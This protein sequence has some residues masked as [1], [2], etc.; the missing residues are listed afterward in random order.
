VLIGSARDSVP[1]IVE[2]DDTLRRG[3]VAMSQAFGGQ[4]D[5]D[6]RYRE[7]GSNTNRLISVDD[8]FDELTGIPRMGALPVA[9]SRLEVDRLVVQATA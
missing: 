9:L 7:L 6:H 4:P 3:V 8:D 1:G 5:E 2:A